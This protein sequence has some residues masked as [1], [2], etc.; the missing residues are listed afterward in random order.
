MWLLVEIGGEEN[1]GVV[2]LFEEGVA[3]FLDGLDDGVL[4]FGLL[5]DEFVLLLVEGH[6]AAVLLVLVGSGGC[7]CGV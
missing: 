6:A 3:L 7:E 2:E 4:E 1:V 5:G